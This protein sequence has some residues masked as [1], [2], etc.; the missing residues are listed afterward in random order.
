MTD[1]SP[2]PLVSIL[3]PTW[4]G[5]QFLAEALD[6]IFAQSYRPLEIVVSDDGSQDDTLAIVQRYQAR[7]TLPM[8]IVTNPD[9]GMVNNW[10]NCIRHASGEFVKFMFQ[11]DL[12]AADC[13]EKLVA[14]AL[15]DASL[16]LVYCRRQLLMSGGAAD[17]HSCRIIFDGCRDLHL[18][19]GS[20][21]PSMDGLRY[22]DNPAFFDEPTNKL[23]EP[24]AVLIRREVFR[25]VGLFDA[26]FI[27]LIDFEMWARIMAHYRIGFVDEALAVFRIHPGQ[28]SVKNLESG[29][30]NQDL[31]LFCRKVLTDAGFAQAPASLRVRAFAIMEKFL[32]QYRHESADFRRQRDRGAQYIENF[33]SNLAELERIQYELRETLVNVTAELSQTKTAMASLQY[34]YNAEHQFIAALQH[35]LNLIYSSRS[36]KLTR[37]L[38]M[39]SKVQYFL[40]VEG[41]GGVI[42][43]IIAKLIRRTPRLPQVK[44]STPGKQRDPLHFTPHAQPLVSI[45]IPVFNK[46]DYTYHCL[47]AVLANSGALPYEVIVVDDCSSDDTADLLK[48]I[49]GIVTLHNEHNSGFILS[50]NA[51]AQAARG[52]FLLMLNN[53]TEVQSGWL[54]ALVNT[55]ADRPDAGMIGAKLL[56]AGGKLQ[57]AGGIVWRDGSAW[58][59]GRG[60][61]PNKPE[62]SY[63]RAVDYCSGAC[64]L[65]RRADY[66]ALGQFDTLF[67]PAYYEDTDLAFK[68]R[69]AGKQVYYQPLA[70]VVHFEGITNGTDTSGGIKAY[71]AANHTKFFERWQSVLENHRPNAFQPQLEKER[72]VY[73]RALVVDARVLMPDND[74]GSLRMFNL[75]KILQTLGYKVTFVPDNMEYHERYTPMLQALGIECW[76][77]PYQHNVTHH[78]VHCGHLYS[79]VILSRAD[80]AENNIDAVLRHAPQAQVLFDTVDLHFLRERRLAALSGN[81]QE[82]EAAEMRRLQELCIARKAHQTLVVSPVEVELFHKE[83]PDVKV[84]LVSNI[85][86]VHGCHNSWAQREHILFIG[87]FEH[88]P[89]VDAMH[90]FIDD[91]MPLLQRKHPG[92][93]LLVV[94]PHAPKALLAKASAVVEFIGFV[95]D[96]VPLFEQVRLSIAPLRYG[97]GVK[98]KI[99]SSMAY[100]VPVVASPIA[101]EGMGLQT[102]VD[103][104]VAD[105]PEAFAAAIVRAHDDEKLWQQLSSG[106]LANLAC[107]FSF[108]VATSQLQAILK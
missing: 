88:P 16:G 37:P 85:H 11:D 86:A 82:A 92:I 12:I 24:T 54:D 56:F 7:G 59:F 67:A 18:G 62:Y 40:R 32:A 38:R 95:P 80:V 20:I 55:F 39:V 21:D 4:Q 43:R 90:Y 50:C 47:K 28:Q 58:N 27:H 53:D 52:E 1:S 84:A 87:N 14:L 64:L 60:D 6:C 34:D 65:L 48:S 61:D 3:V 44:V 94:G 36:W 102:E 69:A 33:D 91:I 35:D 77:N 70:R 101:A 49:D 71:Q 26:G 93:K 104:L 103:V 15:T 97:A 17:N 22:L 98:G 30:I 5:Q 29:E 107:N 108:A 46:S 68:V 2:H 42:R 25:T 106:A 57:E 19:W 99:N 76:Y 83:A 78:L 72:K 75:L 31:M 66:F 73:K 10:N 81:K 74:S 8:T 89:N 51:G 100:G 105:S 13:V 45:V 41:V 63:L 9:Q 96:I 79:L 23:G